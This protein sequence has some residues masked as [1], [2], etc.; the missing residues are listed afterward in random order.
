MAYIGRLPAR[1]REA[2]LWPGL[3]RLV[4]SIMENLMRIDEDD[5][6]RD[7]AW[8]PAGDDGNEGDDGNLSASGLTMDR[9]QGRLGE[10]DEGEEDG[11][12][13]DVAY[14]DNDDEVLVTLLEAATGLRHTLVDFARGNAPV[15]HLAGPTPLLSGRPADAVPRI[16]AD[17]TPPSNDRE[18]REED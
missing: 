8:R 16:I 15:A 18:D 10:D 5:D 1:H 13:G 2:L 6:H 12:D 9:E 11:G 17:A 14:D 4:P 3:G 7:D